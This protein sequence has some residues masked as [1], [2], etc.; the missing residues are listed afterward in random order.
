MPVREFHGE[1]DKPKRVKPFDGEQDTIS[2]RMPDGTVVTN[3]P[4]GTTQTELMRRYKN[5]RSNGPTRMELILEAERRG[6][7][8]QR[9]AAL[10]AEARKRGLIDAPA[11]DGV[12]TP[13]STRARL[14]SQLGFSPQN[15][16]EQF[17]SF[18]KRNVAKALPFAGGIAASL[19]VPGS[20]F[21]ALALQSLA[22]AGGATAGELGR[23]TV[24]DEPLD[25]IKALERGGEEGFGNLIGGGVLKALGAGASKLFSTRLTPE[26]TLGANFAREQ[27][28]PF[29]LS[30]AAPGSAGG[31]TQQILRGTLAGDIRT[32]KDAT[33]V[34]QF[35]N[36]NVNGVA[37]ELAPGARP[38]A[39]AAQKGQ[40]F[41]RSLFE[42]GETRLRETFDDFAGVV[43]RDAQ[44]PRDRTLSAARSALESLKDR[45]ETRNP[46]YTRLRN[47]FDKRAKKSPTQTAQEMNDFLRG[48]QDDSFVKG[49]KWADEGKRVM[50][51]VV[52]DLDD[53]GK[54]FD[55][56]FADAYAKATEVRAEFRKLKEIPGLQ[57]LSR[58]FGGKGAKKGDLDWLSSLFRQG[59]G[60]ALAEIRKTNPDLYHELA[61]SWLA[62]NLNRFSGNTQGVI[63][64]VLDGKQL[65]AWF[66]TNRDLLKEAFGTQQFKV[67]DNF[68]LYAAYMAKAA[69]FADDPTQ[70]LTPREMLFRGAAEIG[71]AGFTTP[72]MLSGEPAAYVLAKGLSDPSSRLF[73]LF[74]QGFP[75][76]TRAVMRR[77]AQ[78]TGQLTASESER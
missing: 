26:Q 19:A 33:K 3:V 18:S 57:A 17:Q 60:K 1:L 74:T 34:A 5:L 38:T 55:I 28:A 54:N 16:P 4:A 14:G 42:P 9:E 49:T 22:A 32:H 13:F 51:A 37:S 48:V 63:G 27:K 75:E 62:H 39:E 76:S 58:E 50:N 20:G 47:M 43:G 70:A 56:N 65:R 7:L 8:P 2:V 67:L 46:L 72:L 78:I 66:E 23:Q 36:R 61:D 31:R 21:G 44:I 6:I 12:E 41:L 71:G 77:S 11:S 59:N 69:R 45:G 53:Y 24:T 52:K 25:P 10:L 40:A 35:L 68:S 73:K 30:S 29:P 15:T 64:R